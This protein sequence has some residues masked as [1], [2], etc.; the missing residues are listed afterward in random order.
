VAIIVN[1][2]H[3]DAITSINSIKE[4]S[5]AEIVVL[6]TQ[7]AKD[8]GVVVDSHT[9][10]FHLEKDPGWGECANALL[11]IATANQKELDRLSENSL[12]LIQSHDIKKTLS[13]FEGL[14][15]G[16]QDARRESDDNLEDYNNPIGRLSE[17]VRRAELRVRRQ[18]LVALGKISELCDD[19]KEGL[20][21]LRA[22]VVKQAKKVD[23]KVRKGVKKTVDNA[24]NKLKRTDE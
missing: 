20:D 9:H 6:A 11:K 5:S 13:I 15:R 4:H 10:V 21:E 22:D 2:F 12:H 7:P 19:I 3:E 18:A 8:L 14:Y 16:D 24:K 23:R 1:G 17:A